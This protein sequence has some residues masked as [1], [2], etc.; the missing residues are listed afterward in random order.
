[1]QRHL[2]VRRM[3]PRVLEAEIATG[4]DK[5]T[6]VL[7]PRISLALSDPAYPIPLR[8]T[9][10]PVKPAFALMVRKAQGQTLKGLVG[11]YLNM[12]PFS[13]GQLHV[14]ASRSSRP[15]GFRVLLPD[16]TD[17]APRTSSGRRSS[18]ESTFFFPPV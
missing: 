11:L 5:G 16:R 9:Q 15:N 10:F 1:M 4:E 2:I 17:P 13:H 7:L 12:S 18:I 3:A 8:R 6:V 14:A